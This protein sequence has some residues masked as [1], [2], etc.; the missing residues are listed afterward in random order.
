VTFPALDTNEI[1]AIPSELGLSSI[2]GQSAA[3][4]AAIELA[5]KVAAS[6][7]TTVLLAG[8]TGTGKE[9]FARGIHYASAAAAEPFVAVNCAAIPETLLESELFGHERGAFT[10]A[11]TQ[12]RGLMEL[13]EGGTLFLDEVHHMPHSLQPK[14]LRVLEERRLRRVGGLDE[15]RICC[16]IIAGTNV[17]LEGAV[18]RHE[19]RE[20]LFYRLNVFR[21]TLPALR[22]RPDDVAPLARHFLAEHAREHGRLP[23]TLD[24]EALSALES[25]FWPGNVRELKNVLERAVI[26]AGSATV[27][28][29]DHLM[30]Q[31]RTARAATP[32]GA[33]SMAV[34]MPA[35]GAN[36]IQIPP[37]GKSLRAIEQ[38]AVRI[39]MQLTGGNRSEA[40][41]V[42]GISRPTLA[43][44]LREWSAEG[45]RSG[46]GER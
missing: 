41:R 33:G 18:E 8:E 20:D 1:V 39:T 26:L 34:V 14:L 45:D 32:V 37:G 12:K 19:F 27:I 25:H 28:R 31:Q 9:L 21:V 24:V 43:R 6:R 42:L 29:A 38:E 17:S 36:G 16:R 3:L 5:R 46:G 4:R 30:I 22:E 44:K 13:A 40:A 10:D 15:T 2:V 11:R 7:T 35:P 23:K